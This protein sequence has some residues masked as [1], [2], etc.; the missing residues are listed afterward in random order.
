MS[1]AR[2][3]DWMSQHMREHESLHGSSRRSGA[4]ENNLV[5]LDRGRFGKT[6]SIG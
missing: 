5:L 6:G 2:F 4:I 1:A 3:D